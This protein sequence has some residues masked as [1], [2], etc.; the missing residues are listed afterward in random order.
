MFKNII[1]SR[2]WAIYI[3]LSKSQNSFAIC[4]RL[5]IVSNLPPDERIMVEVKCHRVWK[6]AS[7]F[8]LFLGSHFCTVPPS[9]ILLLSLLGKC[10]VSSVSSL[11]L[12]AW[13]VNCHPPS[14]H[15]AFPFLNRFLPP[16]LSLF[17]I[18][19]MFSGQIDCTSRIPVIKTILWCSFQLSSFSNWNSNG[20][21][22]NFVKL[23]SLASL[24]TTCAMHRHLATPCLSLLV[25][26]HPSHYHRA[27]EN[28][29]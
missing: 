5:F 19:H 11:W 23:L 10:E 7:A 17:N 12:T 25:W 21:T 8:M 4:Y 26:P 9:V 13:L 22:W 2:A 18:S 3:K 1:V 27:L 14:S 16:Y 24:L 20:K 28:M 29:F 6:S 15:W